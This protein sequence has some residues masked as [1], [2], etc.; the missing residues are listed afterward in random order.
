MCCE[1]YNQ[2][3]ILKREIKNLWYFAFMK[4]TFLKTSIYIAKH[5]AGNDLHGQNDR[6]QN[7]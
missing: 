3:S 4:H 2:D 1:Y 6:R 5:Q 7:S